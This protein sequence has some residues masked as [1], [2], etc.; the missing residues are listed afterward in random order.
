MV[1]RKIGYESQRVWQRAIF[2]AQ[3]ITMES[4]ARGCGQLWR[5]FHAA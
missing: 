1:V 5:L 2:W 4:V 3:L